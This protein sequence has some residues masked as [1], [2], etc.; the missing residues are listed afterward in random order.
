MT[1]S[2]LRH[3]DEIDLNNYM[4]NLEIVLGVVSNASCVF[5]LIYF[6]RHSHFQSAHVAGY[7]SILLS[8]ITKKTGSVIEVFGRNKS[9]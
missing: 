8:A 1:K 7:Q 4:E 5:I 9:Q 6:V 3:L 2:H